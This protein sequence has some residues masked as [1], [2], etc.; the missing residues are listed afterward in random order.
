MDVFPARSSVP[1]TVADEWRESGWVAHPAIAAVE[2]AP[3]PRPTRVLS[4][5]LVFTV[6]EWNVEVRQDPE[7]LYTGEELALTIR[8]FTSGYDL[9]NPSSVVAWHRLHPR[10]NHKYIHD[11]DD[12]EV[13]RR[14]QTAY[15]RLRLLHRGDPDRVLAPYST[16]PLRSVAEFARWSGLDFSARDV[17]DD[18]R[19]GVDPAPYEPAW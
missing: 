2:P 11:G 3:A 10:G 9:F 5:M 7:H 17:S 1:I 19:R 13:Q 12:A 6:G 16:G 14:D 15:R 18:A 8:S 4:G